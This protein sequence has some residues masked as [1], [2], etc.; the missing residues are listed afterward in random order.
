[1]TM[2]STWSLKTQ[3]FLQLEREYAV[4]QTGIGKNKTHTDLVQWLGTILQ[5]GWV[6]L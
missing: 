1:M 6:E 3:T 2:Y 4:V 5:V